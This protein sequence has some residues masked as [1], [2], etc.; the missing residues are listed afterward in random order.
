MFEVA[1]YS[2]KNKADI[3][4]A[5]MYI[6]TTDVKNIPGIEYYQTDNLEIEFNEIPQASWCIDGE[7][8]KHNTNK[9]VF[10]IDKNNKMLLPTENIDVL[11]EEK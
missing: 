7:E 6:T 8:Y 2:I 4:K 3:M 1:V 11:F 9:F 5:I 10:K